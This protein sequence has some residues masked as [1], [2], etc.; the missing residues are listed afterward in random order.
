MK[1]CTKCS[2]YAINPGKHG[3]T[4]EG[5]DLCDICYWKELYSSS[6]LSIEKMEQEIAQY[7]RIIYRTGVDDT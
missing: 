6:L 5:V 2:S 4:G 1:K 7:K 3:R